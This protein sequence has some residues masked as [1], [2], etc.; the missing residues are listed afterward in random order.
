[1]NRRAMLGGLAASTCAAPAAADWLRAGLDENDP[2]L[3]TLA[4]SRGLIFGAA[5]NNF[6]LRDPDFAQACARDCGI[7]VPEY[8]LKRDLTEP[9]PGDYDFSASDVLLSYAQRNRMQFRGHPLVWYASNP[10]WLEPAVAAAKDETVF[11]DYIRRTMLHYRGRMQS[12]DVINEAI[13]P[14]DG[15][16]DGLRDSFWVRRFGASH[17]DRAFHAAHDADPDSLLVYNDYGLEQAGPANDARRKATL[18]LLE[19]LTARGVPVGGLGLQAHINAFGRAIDQKTL[20]AFLEAV[21]A[22]GLRILVT[23]HDVDDTGGPADIVSRDRAVADATRRLLDV[24]LD[25]TATIAVL[26]WGYSDRFLKA[27]STRDQLLR[28]NPRSLPL[29]EAMRPTPMHAALARA[30]TGARKR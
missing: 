28:G 29:D 23:E 1:M 25:N 14:D 21:Q 22:L 7:L 15:R 16:A 2:P 9:A 19:R 18:A 6:W 8:E 30:F 17:I 12:W 10:P 27:E 5:N 4:A 24:V 26:T 11:T 13:E 20:S 3:R